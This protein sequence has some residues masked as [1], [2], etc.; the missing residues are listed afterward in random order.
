MTKAT[1][2]PEPVSTMSPLS[3]SIRQAPADTVAHALEAVFG[4][5]QGQPPADGFAALTVGTAIGLNR[6]AAWTN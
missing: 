4:A 5:L 1:S 6:T 3:W 2:S